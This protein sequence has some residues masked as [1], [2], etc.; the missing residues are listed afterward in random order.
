ML[1]HSEEYRIVVVTDKD[2]VDT[3]FTGVPVPYV[4]QVIGAADQQEDGHIR[5]P[6]LDQGAEGEGHASVAAAQDDDDVKMLPA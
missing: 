2:T 5:V 4:L 3:G 1:D 6:G